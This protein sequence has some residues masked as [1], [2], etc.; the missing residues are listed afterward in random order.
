MWS[1]YRPGSQV[2]T[3]CPLLN[4]DEP[5]QLLHS[6]LLSQVAQE[7]WQAGER[8]RERKSD[9]DKEIERY[10]QGEMEGYH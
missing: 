7:D 6:V 3:H 8:Q 5:S 4:T 9:I 10:G 2:L 1:W